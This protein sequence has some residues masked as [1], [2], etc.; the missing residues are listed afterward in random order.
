MLRLVPGNRERREPKVLVVSDGKGRSREKRLVFTTPSRGL[1]IRA[2]SFVQ[3]FLS[4][5]HMWG[6]FIG[7]SV[8]KQSLKFFL[9]EEPVEGRE[10][11]PDPNG[12]GFLNVPQRI[13]L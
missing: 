6:S 9:L 10:Y 4:M 8:M 12:N 5:L 13:Y 11:P 1:P 3:L 7:T 2:D